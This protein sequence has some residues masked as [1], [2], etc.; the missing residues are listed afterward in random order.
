MDLDPV[1]AALSIPTQ[2]EAIQ[3]ALNQ[4]PDLR[5]AQQTLV[6]AQS[7]LTAAKDAYIP[8]ITALSHYH[9]ESGVPFLVHNFGTFGFSLN[10]DLFDGGRRE[11]AVRGARTDVRSTE[12]AIAKLQAEIEVQIRAIYDRI[13]ELRQMVDVA[14]QV[15][16]VRTEAAR[17]ADR[18]FEQ[19]AAL[20]SARSQAHADLATATASLLEANCGLTL[21]EADMKRAIGQRPQ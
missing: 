15:V 8:D 18:Q 7:G 13:D 19:N 21:A 6:K 9:Y 10:Y 12:V 11:A 20:G 5:V 14:G 3:I 17:L 1:V 16:A 4:N 2:A